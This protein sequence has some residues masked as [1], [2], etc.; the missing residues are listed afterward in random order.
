[1]ATLTWIS[2][3]K[4]ILNV[5]WYVFFFP[6]LYPVCVRLLV[7][8]DEDSK[9]DDHRRLPHEANCRETNANI[10]VLWTV[11]QIPEALHA[12]HFLKLFFLFQYFCL[13]QEV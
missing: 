2:E 6:V 7:V 11:T 1:M 13:F 10:C 8:T 9:Q 4:V 12:A 5:T 3:V